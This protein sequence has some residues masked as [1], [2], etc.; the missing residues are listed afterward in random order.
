MP[1]DAEYQRRIQLA[2]NATLVQL[3]ERIEDHA[4]IEGWEPGRALEYVLLRQFQLEG[5]EVTWP[6]RV[7]LEERVVEQIDGVVY[8]VGI[9]CLLECKDVHEPVDV[10]PLAKLR[11]QLARRPSGTLGVI[12]ARSGYTRPAKLLAQYMTPLSLL[13]WE[14]EELRY[15]VQGQRLVS[16]LLAKYRYAVERAMPDYDI[17]TGELR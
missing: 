17:R 8:C 13:L 1:T 4:E 6:F 9:S 7:E 5:A 10:E 2:D 14:F 16:G 11:N 12:V 3:L 15:A